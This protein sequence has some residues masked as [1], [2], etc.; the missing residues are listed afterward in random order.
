MRF[1]QFNNTTY[2][3]RPTRI[4]KLLEKRQ[5]ESAESMSNHFLQQQIEQADKMIAQLTEQ[6]KPYMRE[7]KIVSRIN[8]KLTKARREKRA[9]LERL[10][11]F[12]E[13]VGQ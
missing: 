5:A 12:N 3:K 6:K 9:L 4:G 10:R 1:S 8:R 11:Q 7:F 2:R 13:G